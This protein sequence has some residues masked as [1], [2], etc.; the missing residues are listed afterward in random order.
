MVE[1]TIDFL[2]DLS[3][4]KFGTNNRLFLADLVLFECAVKLI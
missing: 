4:L 1:W 3:V 2:P